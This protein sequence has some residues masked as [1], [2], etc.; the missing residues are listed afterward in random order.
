MAMV[1]VVALS[2]G[3]LRLLARSRIAS[4][5][6]VYTSCRP[7]APAGTCTINVDVPR[8]CRSTSSRKKS[9]AASAT[10]HDFP[11]TMKAAP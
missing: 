5:S 9:P 7:V 11:V 3:S 10:G 4:T 1:N 2:V 6:N 8:P